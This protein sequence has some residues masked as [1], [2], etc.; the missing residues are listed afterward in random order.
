MS[1]PSPTATSGDQPLPALRWNIP[2]RIGFL[3]ITVY[4]AFLVSHFFHHQLHFIANFW[5]W[6]VIRTG[7]YIPGLTTPISIKP[8]GSGDTTY[9]YVMQLLWVL[10][11]LIIAI[12]WAVL[13]RKRASYRQLCYWLRIV[14]RYYFAY[15]LL[16]YGFVKIIKIQFLFPSLYKLAAPFGDSSPM[17]LAWSFIGYSKAYNFFTGSA[18]F[19]AG[20]LLFFRRT[21]LLGA[22]IGL[23]IMTNVAAINLCY[24]VPVK[25]F[26][27][28]LVFVAIFLISHDAK[29]LYAFF[30]Q[31]RALPSVTLAQP[32]RARWIKPL[33]LSIKILFILLTFYSTFWSDMNI[34]KYYGDNRVKPALYG[35]YD[36]EQFSTAGTSF[37]SPTADSYR[38]KRLI[39]DHPGYARIITKADSITDVTC[40]IDTGYNTASFTS[41][42]DGQYTLTYT[43]PDKDHLLFTGIIR[44]DS[45]H[46]TMKRFDLNKFALINRHFRWINEYP[47]NR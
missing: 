40:K 23:T 11:A 15:V 18:E 4:C 19:L 26:S 47:D 43:E 38:W 41:D 28:N 10:L 35:I 29:R 7:K 6:A 33:H 31:H 16:T 32:P 5:D 42:Y 44:G 27:L 1:K 25:I 39:I 37:S 2:K 24:D 36:T 22:L 9:N 45:V 12:I 13:D 17:G 8:N 20:F 21:T 3:F 46:I 14:I 34:S 30:F